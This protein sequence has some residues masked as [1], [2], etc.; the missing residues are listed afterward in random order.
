MGRLGDT[1][2]LRREC[3]D[4]HGMDGPAFAE[5]TLD[6]LGGLLVRVA[7]G[8]DALPDTFRQHHARI[9]DGISRTMNTLSREMHP[10]RIETGEREFDV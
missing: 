2:R 4:L 7:P 6:Y 1:E 10:A 9:C 5:K 8:S 3:R